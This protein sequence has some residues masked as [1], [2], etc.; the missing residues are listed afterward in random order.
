M[1]LDLFFSIFFIALMWYYSG[2]LTAIVLA[3]LPC[4]VLLSLGVTP[5][6]RAR[7][8]EKFA[9]G[10]ENQ[11]FLV[12]SISAID[13]VKAMAVEPQ[14]TR[15]WDN[16]LAAYV[17]ASFKSATVST[18]AHEGVNLISK[19]VTVGT[20]WLG[21]RLVIAGPDEGMLATIQSMLD[22]TII[23]TGYLDGT[24]RLAAFAGADMLALPAVGEG[25][26]MVVLEAMASGL[27]VIISPGCNLPEVQA[28]GAGIQVDVA[29]E[30]L[31]DALRQ[32]LTDPGKRATMGAAAAAL[33]AERFTWEIIARQLEQVYQDA[34]RPA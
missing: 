33:V 34:V 21:A 20:M 27:A 17:A 18:I 31:R 30:P 24:D 15:R 11:A 16:Q 13:T 1:V 12:E 22:D 7:L 25:L 14:M 19:L 9:R 32:L 6:L 28:N 2:P 29:L 10:A 5:L 4:Y 26:P 8:N 3:S 23:Y